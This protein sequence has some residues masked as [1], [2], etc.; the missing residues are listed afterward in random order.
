MAFIYGST[1]LVDL[2]RFFSFLIYTPSEG[3]FD[4]GSARR[5]AATYTQNNTNA[6]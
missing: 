5:E 2:Y 1:T 6:E 3:P 4:G